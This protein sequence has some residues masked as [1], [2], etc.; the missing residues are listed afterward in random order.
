MSASSGNVRIRRIIS[1]EWLRP[2]LTSDDRLTAALAR[3]AL[4]RSEVG[5]MRFV[6]ALIRKSMATGPNLTAV[7]PKTV[8][9]GVIA[10]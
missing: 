9:D 1:A 10:D 4:E 7:P 2:I 6:H 3:V 5:D 8:W